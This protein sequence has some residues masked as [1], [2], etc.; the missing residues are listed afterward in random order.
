MLLEIFGRMIM[1]LSLRVLFCAI[2][3]SGF[4]LPAQAENTDKQANFNCE[5]VREPGKKADEELA[6]VIYKSVEVQNIHLSPK[7]A[8]RHHVLDSLMLMKGFGLS[9]KHIRDLGK[10][11]SSQ[12]FNLC[13]ALEKER[14]KLVKL[15]IER[16][17]VKSNCEIASQPVQ[18]PNELL[19]SQNAELASKMNKTIKHEVAV[20]YPMLIN[21]ILTAESSQFCGSTQGEL[22]EMEELGAEKRG[23][24]CKIL[25]DERLK[26]KQLD[27][28][29]EA[30]KVIAEI[31]AIK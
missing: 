13:R 19:V 27:I 28:S 7:Q 22:D 23:K 24:L 15:S 21:Q 1:L 14:L 29:F 25:E 31:L 12:R 18:L 10:L 6:G 30:E 3:I 8:D 20:R 26:L 16:D 17:S 9:I 2:F 11:D 4:I 5:V